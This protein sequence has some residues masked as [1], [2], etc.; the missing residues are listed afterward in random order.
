VLLFMIQA[1]CQ[2]LFGYV[3]ETISFEFHSLRVLSADQEEAIKSQK[4]ERIM[5]LFDSK[6]VPTSKVIELMNAEKIFALDLDAD[7]TDDSVEPALGLP[8]GEA[9]QPTDD[10][11]QSE[12]LN[13]AQVSSLVEIIAQITA[14]LIPKD[15]AAAII[16]AAFPTFTDELIAKIISPIQESSTDADQTEGI[17]NSRIFGLFKRQ[18]KG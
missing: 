18:T 10:D 5:R 1:R 9:L 14:G 15:S 3:P 13:G 11:Y 7:E 2:Q 8:E 16:K 6:L 4:F 12:A 17:E